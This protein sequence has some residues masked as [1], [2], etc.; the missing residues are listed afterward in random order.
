[1]SPEDKK[2]SFFWL[3]Y[4]DLMILVV[5]EVVAD[6]ATFNLNGDRTGWHFELLYMFLQII[7]D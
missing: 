2:C 4:R 3:G 7:Y 5:G 1:M 6:Q